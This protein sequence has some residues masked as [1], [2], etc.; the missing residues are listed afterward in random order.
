VTFSRFEEIVLA[1]FEFNGGEGNRPNVV[2]LV[3]YELRSGRGFRLWR[4]QLGSEPPYRVD[5]RT[6]FVAY[7]ASAELTCHLA[8]G[9]PMPRNILD[10]F[11]EYRNRTNHSNEV[12]PPAGL[13]DALDHFH[14]D[15]ISLQTKK[16]WRD[17]VLRGGP[18]TTEER[19]GILEYCETDVEPLRR[20]L[21]V[22]PI[23]NLDHALIHGAYMRADAWMRHWGVP[24]DHP[25]VVEMSTRW[26]ELRRG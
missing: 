8:L 10:L 12:Q 16:H 5:D 6:L 2:C 23:A 22:F 21:D 24:L 3:S 11:V 25:L 4:D 26:P 18:W 9:W 13:L 17:V 7:Y 1:D 19:A 20:L 15:S 14:L